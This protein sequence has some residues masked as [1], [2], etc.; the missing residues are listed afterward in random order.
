MAIINPDMIDPATT[1]KQVISVFSDNASL[2]EARIGFECFLDSLER[3]ATQLNP[4]ERQQGSIGRQIAIAVLG[5]RMNAEE[6]GTTRSIIEER[7]KATEENNSNGK[8][9]SVAAI[10]AKTA[11]PMKKDIVRQVIKLSTLGQVSK[12][13]I[14]RARLV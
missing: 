8:A 13:G 10:P 2:L 7:L 12:F 3:N 5:Q 6:L 9:T 4:Q 14:T 1:F 11:V